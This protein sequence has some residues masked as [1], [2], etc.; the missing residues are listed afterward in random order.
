MVL[1]APNRLERTA[2]SLV[3]AGTRRTASRDSPTGPRRSGPDLH[4]QISKCSQPIVQFFTE[5]DL[6]SFSRMLKS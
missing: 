2:L 1:P 6:D 4:N 3:L 5:T